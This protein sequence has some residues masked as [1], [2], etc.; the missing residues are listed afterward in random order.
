MSWMEN[1]IPEEQYDLETGAQQLYF[2]PD[3][4]FEGSDEYNFV[5]RPLPGRRLVRPVG[6]TI[7]PAVRYTPRIVQPAR[8][9]APPRPAVTKDRQT[10]E[11]N[12]TMI[13]GGYIV[14]DPVLPAWFGGLLSE[15]LPVGHGAIVKSANGLLL[16]S[17]VSKK[18]DGSFAL[19]RFST[20]STY[21]VAPGERQVF[22]SLLPTNRPFAAHLYSLLRYGTISIDRI[23][24]TASADAY[25]P[26][27]K[28]VA[29]YLVEVK[30][31]RQEVVNTLV[32]TSQF[33][34]DQFQQGILDIDFVKTTGAPLVL[35]NERF[36]LLDVKQDALAAFPSGGV[37]IMTV[38][39]QNVVFQKLC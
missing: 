28:S 20:I 38:S 36:I 23:R 7:Q 26:Y 32:G 2:E 35:T 8:P 25:I 19:D 21:G 3:P 9:V 14:D 6:R 13:L 31:L 1:L 16:S 39:F 4:S 34:P 18:V 5:P 12:F 30:A 11:M 27:L 15:E 29:I 37:N 33:T 10:G 24:L 17:I 22:T